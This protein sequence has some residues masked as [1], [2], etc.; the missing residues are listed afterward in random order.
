MKR[1]QKVLLGSIAVVA[2]LVGTAWTYRAE[3][4]LMG[5]KRMSA[6]QFEIGPTREIEWSTGASA[7]DARPPNIILIVADDLGINDVSYTNMGDAPPTVETPNIDALA[8]SGVVFRNGYAANG[9][10]APS[11]AALMSGRYG[12]RFGFEF[13]PTPTNMIPTIR[14]ITEGIERPLAPQSYANDRMPEIEYADMGLPTS[15]VTLANVLSDRGY[16]TMHIG[17]WHLGRSAGFAPHERGFDESI[18]M[19]S[20]LYGDLDDP[21]VIQARQDFDPIDR[22]LW[23]AMQFVASFNGGPAFKPPKYLTDWYTDE[24]VAAIEANKDRPFF[25]YL[26]HWAPHTPLQA[27]AEDYAALEGVEPHRKRVYAAMIRALDRGVGRVMDALRDQGLDEN[28]LVLF[29]SDNGGAGY[30]GLPDVNDPLRGW[31]ITLFEGGIHVPFLASWPDRLPAGEVYEAPVHHVDLWATA[32]AAGGATPPADRVIDGVD[33]VPFVI[34]ERTDDPHEHL[35]FRSGAAESVRRGPWKMNVS[36]P[37]GGERKEWL[38]N[39]DDD[40]GEQNDLLASEPI[41][42][43]EL[44]AALAAHNAELVE[45]LWPWSITTPQNVDRDLSQ[46]DQP[47][48]EFAYWSN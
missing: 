18:L 28:T 5:V 48:D 33:L 41:V 47:G 39:L 46:P 45:P 7:E 22:F 37:P 2:L 10:C 42:A 34:G 38:F 43:A 6:A 20:G 26:A 27:S 14:T 19:A 16:H 32:A 17:K 30:I 4:I 29:T 25:L 36:T 11:R 23:A 12:T 3:L 21:E 8:A 44:R 40:P 9:T 35:F 15:E 24:A 31:K 13:T 1:W